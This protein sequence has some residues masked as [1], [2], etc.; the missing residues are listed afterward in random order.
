MAG[1]LFC[2]CF[3]CQEVL[4]HPDAETTEEGL[5]R[6]LKAR[7]NST[8]RHFFLVG[9]RATTGRISFPFLVI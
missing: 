8:D 1:A 5:T 7:E 3:E 9:G 2:F 4:G 6:R